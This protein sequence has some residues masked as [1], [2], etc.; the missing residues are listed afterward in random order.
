MDRPGRTTAQS[1]KKR[2]HSS[3]LLRFK[4]YF[5]RLVGRTWAFEVTNTVYFDKSLTGG[6]ERNSDRSRGCAEDMRQKDTETL[7]SGIGKDFQYIQDDTKIQVGLNEHKGSRIV[8]HR[9][10]KQQTFYREW[11]YGCSAKDDNGDQPRTFHT[12]SSHETRIDVDEGDGNVKQPKFFWNW[13]RGD[14]VTTN[15]NGL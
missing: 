4:N 14:F 12:S 3:A 9:E 15:N 2:K 11:W 13:K 8:D 1:G 6:T 10:D 5:D 7:A